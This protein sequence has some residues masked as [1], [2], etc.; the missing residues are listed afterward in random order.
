MPDP[1][2]CDLNCKHFIRHAVIGLRS[3]QQQAIKAIR[4]QDMS[5]A[6]KAL[7]GQIEH[8]EMIEATLKREGLG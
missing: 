4:H 7:Y 5:A 3:E 6:I 8:F 1:R 2:L